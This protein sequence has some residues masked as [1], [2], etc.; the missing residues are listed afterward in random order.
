MTGRRCC[1]CYHCRE[2]YE[3]EAAYVKQLK[4]TQLTHKKVLGLVDDLQ[5]LHAALRSLKA[6]EAEAASKDLRVDQTLRVCC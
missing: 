2:L 5:G 1:C 3:V 4:E 6:L